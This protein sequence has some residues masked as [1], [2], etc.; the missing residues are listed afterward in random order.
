M[1]FNAV[2]MFFV[3]IGILVEN[4]G[5]EIFVI[6]GTDVNRGG[7]VFRALMVGIGVS[8]V[9]IQTDIRFEIGSIG[10]GAESQSGNSHH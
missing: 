2:N 6:F 1:I 10:I 3:V 4:F 8:I 7:I 9:I 5:S